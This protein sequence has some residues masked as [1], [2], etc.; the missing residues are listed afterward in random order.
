MKDH[1][2]ENRAGASLT[3][4]RPPRVCTWCGSEFTDGRGD[5]CSDEHR[6]L[7]RTIQAGSIPQRP[8]P[9]CGCNDLRIA[10]AEFAICQTCGFQPDRPELL[11]VEL[12]PPACIGVTRV[13][14]EILNEHG[15]EVCFANRP[16]RKTTMTETTRS[17]IDC[18]EPIQYPESRCP[19]CYDDWLETPEGWADKLQVEKWGD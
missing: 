7:A 16:G 14:R 6:R 18:G 2:P 5:Y 11:I 12:A 13:K 15:C 19:D 1:G 3:T 17:C 4:R 9:R 8:C 10:A